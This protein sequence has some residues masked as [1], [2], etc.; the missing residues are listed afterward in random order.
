MIKRSDFADEWFNQKNPEIYNERIE[1]ISSNVLLKWIKIKEND[2]DL[3]VGDYVTLS[4]VSM[5]NSKNRNEISSLLVEVL[6]KMC[7]D[8]LLSKI[9]VV[10][11][12]NEEMISDSIGPKTIRKIFVSAHL[13]DLNEKIH[14]GINNCAAI[15][16]K[17]MGQTGLESA[18]I[19]KGVVDFYKPNCVLVIDALSSQSFSRINRAIQISNIGIVP[20]SGVGNHRLALDDQSLHI[21]VISIGIATVTTIQAILDE[22]EIKKEHENKDCII[23]PRDMDVECNQIV[24]I[25]AHAINCF[26]H[27]AY[28]EL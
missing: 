12:G 20:G 6:D 26:I 10:G 1:K 24:A 4:F 27:P 3:K 21:P 2:Q 8:I 25:L 22:L 16:P 14:P 28:E 18:K 11:L 9:L 5:D 7:Q 13:Y 17:V 19:V 15:A 23:T